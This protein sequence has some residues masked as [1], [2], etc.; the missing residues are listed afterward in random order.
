[1][2]AAEPTEL[3]PGRRVI[4]IRARGVNKG[5]YLDRVLPELPEGSAILAAGDDLT[6]VDLFRRLPGNAIAIHVGSA[7]PRVDNPLLRDRYV[8]DTPG[9]LRE[10]LRNC[11]VDMRVL[12][13]TRSRAQ[14][15]AGR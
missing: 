7:R 5:A 14:T 13:R 11:V 9:A 12:G 15:L 2:L 4:E 8:V 10:A 1:M 3:L 6:D